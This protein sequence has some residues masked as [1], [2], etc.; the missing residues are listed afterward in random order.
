MTEPLDAQGR[1][2]ILVHEL[3]SPVA[4]LAAIEHALTAG[5]VDERAYREL[6]AL[7]IGACRSIARLVVDASVSSVQ[8]TLLEVEDVLRD[9]SAAAALRGADVRMATEPGVPQV[10]ADPVRVRQVLENLVAN[11]LAHS[12]AGAPVVLRARALRG[13]VLVSVSDEGPGI[14]PEGLSRAFEPGER[15]EATYPGSGLGLA[16]S[17]AIAEAH[18]G[19]LT[20]ESKPGEGATFTLALPL[21]PGDRA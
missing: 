15:L 10:R 18:G 14:S 21:E 11:A 17:R 12:P 13:E 19:R 9:V 20:V 2:A 16:V 4:A 1:L 5:D 8:R 7:A 3:R 6:L